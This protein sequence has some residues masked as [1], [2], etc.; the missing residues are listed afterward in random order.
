[1]D[2]I[3]NVLKPPGMTSFDVVAYLRSLFKVKKVGHTGT[4]DPA[5][6]GVL[7]VCIGSATKASEFIMGQSKL[8]RVEL[9]LGLGTDTQDLT[10]RITN[11]HGVDASFEQIRDIIK[12]FRGSYM[13]IPP[14]YSALKVDGKKL[15]DLARKGI[16]VERK[17]REVEIFSIEILDMKRDS[18]K[19]EVIFC[20]KYPSGYE[21]GLRAVSAG[22]QYPLVKVILD[23]ECSKGTYI[24][25]LCADIGER[26]GCGGCMSFL[27]RLK[28]GFFHI[29]DSLTLEEIRD[30]HQNGRL[31]DNLVKVDLKSKKLFYR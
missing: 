18:F 31:M 24:R 5:A 27:V 14:M 30:L 4:L 11:L 17:P 8:Y 29:S 23:V 10:G 7:P 21:N 22:F 13:Q 12:G 9:I 20:R 6:A 15:Y 1:M 25:T 3:L 16:T 19:P 28:T 26:L 2:G